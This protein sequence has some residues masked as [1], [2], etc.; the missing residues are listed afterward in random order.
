MNSIFFRSSREIEDV[1]VSRFPSWRSPLLISSL[2]FAF[3]WLLGFAKYQICWTYTWG[4]GS[5]HWERWNHLAMDTLNKTLSVH[6]VTLLAACYAPGV[7]A[8]W[9]QII[10]GTK[11]SR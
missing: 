4:D 2:I 9:I 3:Q 5:W 7:L 1:P 8:A 6:A 11:Y 10:R